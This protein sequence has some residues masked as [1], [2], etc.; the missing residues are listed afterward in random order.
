MHTR[1]QWRFPAVGRVCGCLFLLL[2]LGAAN[3]ALVRAAEGS[4]HVDLERQIWEVRSSDLAAILQDATSLQ[5][6]AERLAQP[7]ASDIRDLRAQF[8]RLSGLY[9]AS[10][11]HPTEQLTVVQQMHALRDTLEDAV[12][13]LRQIANTITQ[14]LDEIAGVQQDLSSLG[15]DGIAQAQD[16]AG[17]E[18]YLASLAE[19]QRQ[20]NTASARLQGILAPAAAAL[21]RFD[22]TVAEVEGNL[23]KIWERYYLTPSGNSFADLASTPSLIADWASSFDF[24]MGFAYPHT[25]GQWWEALKN[26]LPMGI[27]MGLLGFLGLG[28][29]RELPGQWRLAAEGV[30]TRAWIWI[31]VGAAVLAASENDK[32]GIFFALV[33]LGALILIAGIAALNWR[34]RLAM[35]PRLAQLPS[36]LLRLYPA[37]AFGVVML[38]SDLPTRILGIMW[39]ITMVGFLAAAIASNRRHKIAEDLPALERGVQKSAFF[40]GLASL[41]VSL[42]GYARLAILLYM[43]LFALANIVTLGNALTA[44]F[45]AMLNRFVPKDRQPVRNAV[46][47]AISIPAAWA[48]SLLCTVPWIWAVPGASYVLR[49]LSSTEYSLGE[50]SFDFSKLMVI[51]VLFFLFRSFINLGRTYLDHLP[52]RLP[53]LERGVIPPLRSLVFYALWTVFALVS[54]GLLGVNFTSLAVVAGGLSVGIGFGMQTLFNNLIS[55]LMLIFGRTMLVGDVVDVPGASGTVQAI[56][57]RSTIIQTADR[58]QVFVPNSAIMS[59]QV[60]NWT[61]N[62]RMVRRSVEVGVAYGSDPDLVI[63]LLLEIAGRQEHVLAVPAPLAFFTGFGDSALNFSLYC[64]MDNID[65]GLSTQSAIRTEIYRVFAERGIDIPFPQ[66]NVLLPGAAGMRRENEPAPEVSTEPRRA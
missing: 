20:L 13:P 10:R 51:V 42:T 65:F 9:Q 26:S 16:S 27:I 30:I 21:E 55:G 18:K 48:L 64:Y 23:P 32:G 44:L 17:L 59:G 66:L 4:S 19:G 31:G 37:A 58:S 62:G 24:R 34:L 49:Q 7:L 22:A 3:G 6:Q 14:R 33:L 47:H 40:F 39:G 63:S 57:I 61:R 36:P 54:L 56:N 45:G 43:L 35:V 29:A 46:I 1:Q 2:M 12:A 5:Q 53:N 60:T 52:D 50:A 11:G 8:S 15:R 38:F 41:L 28:L 25:L